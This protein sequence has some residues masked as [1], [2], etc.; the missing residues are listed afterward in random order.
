M[1]SGFNG[2]SVPD[3][4]VPSVGLADVDRSLFDLF[5]EQIPLIVGG[6]GQDSKRVPVVFFAGEKWALNKRLRALRDRNGTLILPLITA[7]RSSVTQDPGNDITG[8]GTNQQTGEIV[9]SRRL[10]RSDRSY[11]GLVNRL[12]LRNQENASS[13]QSGDVGQLSTRREIGDLS[14]TAT[15]AGGGLLLPD[16]KRN[17][18]ETIVIPAPQFFTAQYDITLWAQYTSHMNQMLEAII[19]SFLPQGNAW[20]LE[21]PGG[22]WFIAT[23]DG[24]VY[25]ADLNADDYSQNERLI[26]YKMTVKVPGYVLA[27]SVPGAPVPVR[28]YVSSPEVSFSVSTRIDIDSSPIG[29]GQR[30][31]EPFLGADDPTLPLS[32]GRSTGDAGRADNRSTERTLLY[33]NRSEVSPHDPALR[34]IGRGQ[35][36]SSYKKINVVAPDGTTSERYARIKGRNEQAG[37]TV[38]SGFD[39]GSVVIAAVD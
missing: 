18:Y 21:T 4:T 33:P 29:D 11:Q 13:L 38:L 15:V 31:V 26:R 16:K 14:R 37:E 1:Q 30:V 7:V 25:T 9:V 23:V 20:R 35:R 36:L 12:M 32:H 10:D 17:V 24:N 39:L 34:N 22:Y 5:N 28:R 2:R 27:S 6:D 8:R 19:G 3:V